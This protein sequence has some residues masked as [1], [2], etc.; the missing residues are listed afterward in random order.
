MK[1]RG[2]E[3][4]PFVLI[5]DDGRPFDRV[6]NL[7]EVR[8]YPGTV[9]TFDCIIKGNCSQNSYGNKLEFS[10]FSP[11]QIHIQGQ[12]REDV[13]STFTPWLTGED[14]LGFDDFDY[15][16]EAMAND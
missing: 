2:Y 10:L 11:T 13:A 4:K 12:K 16:D 7:S 14:G 3:Y 9:A 5:H 15:E 1:A 6:K 8:V